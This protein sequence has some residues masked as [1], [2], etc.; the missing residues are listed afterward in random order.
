[1]R[2]ALIIVCLFPFSLFAQQ[3]DRVEGTWRGAIS[4]SGQ[5]LGF[6]VTFANNEGVLDGT[7]DIPA[8]NAFNLPV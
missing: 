4:I 2:I 7:L 6:S 1:M 3:P 8:Q 5:E